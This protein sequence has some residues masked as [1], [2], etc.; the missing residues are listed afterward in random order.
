MSKVNQGLE[1]VVVATTNIS[2]VDGVRG[3]LV[4]AGYLLEEL[5]ARKCS[6]E[7]VLFLLLK[8]K[9]PTPQES[10]EFTAHLASK[11]TLS[12]QLEAMIDAMPR[13]LD[14]IDA[15]RTGISALSCEMD[16]SYPPTEEQALNCIAKAPLILSRYHRLKTNQPLLVSDPKLSHVANYLYLLTGKDPNT[17]NNK[18]Y[19]KALETYFITTIEHG[20]NAS[21]FGARVATSTQ[22]DLISSVSAA[23]SVLKGPLHGGAPSEVIHMLDAIGSKENAEAW[24]RKELSA[25]RRIMGFGHRVYKTHDPRA[26]ALLEVV[27]TLPFDD[28]NAHLELS[29]HVE[30]V[31]I[32]VLQELKPNKNLYTNVEFGAAAVLR[33]VGLPEALYPAT[34]GLSRCGGWVA[35]ILELSK[36]NRL[37]R[38]ASEYTGVWPQKILDRKQQIKETTHATFLMKM[39]AHPATKI[40][41]AIIMLASVALLAVMTIGYVSLGVGCALAATSFAVGFGFFAGHHTAARQLEKQ[42]EIEGVAPRL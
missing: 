26:N 36:S 11:R 39:L 14:Y 27:K 5:I 15:L 2:N 37:I 19:S 22:S 7:D 29:R 10:L 34:F 30:Q 42:P 6:Y 25:G 33:A 9:L 4:Y 40:A 3:E 38:P 1:G 23:L 8:N 12:P 21:T 24:I 41:S 32:Q 13:D 28:H 17:V 35:H 20:M 18:A 16:V 31:A